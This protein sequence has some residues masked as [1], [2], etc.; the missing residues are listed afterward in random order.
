MNGV[1]FDMDDVID[2]FMVRSQKLLLPPRM[3][4][5]SQSLFSFITKHSFDHRVAKRI[6]DINRKLD[7]IQK[8][9]NMFGLERTNSQHFQVNVV[10]K[11]QTS[12]IDELEVFGR[13]I[14]QATDDIVKRIL[15]N[16]DENGPTV[17]GIQGMGGIGK[18]TL[19]QKIY[20]EQWIREKFQVH[21]WLCISQ[22]YTEIGLLRQAIRMAGAACDQLET[23]TE[24][25][26]HLMD[27]IRGKNVFLVL[28]DVWKSDVWID[29][30]R[31]PFE[32]C[33][34]ANILVTTRNLDV[35]AGMHA[36]YTHQVNKMNDYDGLEL[37]MKSFR[38]YAQI[39]EFTDVGYQIV[40]KCDGLPL[41]I[42]VVAGVLST[43][44]TREEWESIRDGEWSIHG[45]P[46]ELGGP[47]Y[48]SY[49]SL[50][51]QLKQCFLWCA[52]LPPNFAIDRNAVVYCWV[53][54]GFVRKGHKYSIYEIAEEYYH[55][56]IRRNLLQPKPEFVDKA[57]STMHD[58]LRSLGQYLTRHHSLF[59]NAENNEALPN[60]RRISISSAVE[61]IPSME[62]QK[63]VR[64]LLIFNNKNF[65]SIH[66]NIFRK[67]EHIRI[68]V[69][70][71]TGILTMP[72]SVGNLVL[73]GLLDLSYTEISKLPDSIGRLISLEYL[74]LRGCHKLDSLPVSLMRLS[75][76]CFL[77]LEQTAI[78]HVPKG[79]AMFQQ[80][81][82]LRGVFERGT[83]FRLDE[84]KCL[85]NIR[86][87]WI[88]KLEKAKPR[89]AL[90]LRESSKLKELGLCCTR[91]MDT[92][93]RTYYHANEID[94][95]E[96]VYEMLMPS[97][98]L[99]YIFLVGFPGARFPEW[100]CS[101]PERKLPNLAHMLLN[102]CISCSHLPPA[103]QMPEL[104]VLQIRGADAVVTSEYRRRTPWERCVQCS[105]FFFPKLELLRL[106]DMR[107]LESWSLSTGNLC[108][109]M[110][111]KSRQ[112][113]MM[114]FLKRLWLKDC[115]KLKALPED[116]HR[117]ANLKRIHIEGAHKLQEVV[118]LPEV[119]WLKVKNNRSLRR[120]SNLHKLQDLLARVVQNLRSLKRL[121][122][123][124]CL[125]AQQFRNCLLKKEQDILVHVATVGV[126]GQD[127]FPDESLYH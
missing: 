5:C 18:T 19:A 22:S 35:L 39:S 24:L 15:S 14:R 116:L 120:I 29:L 45:L 40:K 108:D 47:L 126:D 66:T 6:K 13:E 42:V 75:Q 55:E 102:E 109:S 78:D 2:H 117:A 21:I 8:N 65:K 16:F 92:Y 9:R 51:P 86:H 81:Y 67:L 91:G 84:L 28:D 60:L 34:N 53:A 119:V 49:S 27:T 127:I 38:P 77:Q 88:E 20:N 94:K 71:G 36:T 12:P 44:R 37:L 64:S 93:N 105:S 33:S 106:I 10:D 54:E 85:P 87:L 70:S 46:K 113:V 83:G 25:L 50:P 114:P 123:V 69:L 90:V 97:P 72:E 30:L 31:S 100:L 57:I 111:A 43:K 74:S 76:I 124:D 80:L 41:A 56:L 103:G 99:V 63:C 26:L 61:E 110:K 107:N 118:N 104:L 1:M 17:F 52:L 79:I 3:V 96:K 7:E 68:L 89:G 32:R 48:L 101:E 125:N 98:S 121:Y 4:C 62:E 115:P 95:V 59:M 112:L 82:Y 122:M 58:L 23:K 11:S 73:L